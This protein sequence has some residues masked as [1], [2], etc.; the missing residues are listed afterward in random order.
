MKRKHPSLILHTASVCILFLASCTGGEAV[1]LKL[2]VA[3][4]DAFACKVAIDQKVTTSA[5][6]INMN[7]DQVMEISQTLSVEDVAG[8]SITF[9]NVMDRF[10]MK[11]SMPMMPQPLVFD[12]DHPEK[13]GPMGTMG[14]YFSKMK[15][16]TYRVQMNDRGKVLSSNMDDV[17]EKMGLD[18]LNLQGGNNHSGNNAE[19]YLSELPETPIRKGDT[20]VVENENSGFGAFGTKS[21]Y[22]VKEITP[23][24]VTLDIRTEF[25]RGKETPENMYKNIKGSQTGTVTIDRKTGMTLKSET[26]QELDM[27]ISNAGME[28]PM[29][30]S[31]TAIFTCEKK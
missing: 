25:I 16:L 28:M 9:K 4:G 27:V 5:L 13:I 15:G 22:T 6:G 21:T 14:I 19:T 1:D 30:T 8:G 24:T 26:K 23:E 7:I 10:Y 31:G 20:Y 12:T 3:K 29:K 17:Y 2:N 18:S 11:Q